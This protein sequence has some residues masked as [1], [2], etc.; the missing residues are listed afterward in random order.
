VARSEAGPVVNLIGARREKKS[1]LD[2]GARQV[3]VDLTRPID[4]FC[5]TPGC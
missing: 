1:R 5:N 2:G 4:D 3:D